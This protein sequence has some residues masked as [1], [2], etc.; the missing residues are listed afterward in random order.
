MQEKLPY[1]FNDEERKIVFYRH[2]LPSPWSNYLSNGQNARV[3]YAGGGG[4]V[5]DEVAYDLSADA[6]S[7][8]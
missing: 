6:L 2:D 4:K 1:E 8:L 7:L 5:L 3:R